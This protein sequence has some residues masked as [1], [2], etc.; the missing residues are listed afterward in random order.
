VCRRV[1]FASSLNPISADGYLFTDP[2]HASERDS[3]RHTFAAVKKLP[4]DILITAHPF[5]SGGDEKARRLRAG[6]EP[7]PFLDPGA[8]RT[9]AEEAE[10]AF[11]RRIADEKVA[12]VK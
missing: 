4:C 10:R 7:N 6:E 11:D 8:C 1:V 5:Q 3:F 12:R 2:A 9:Y